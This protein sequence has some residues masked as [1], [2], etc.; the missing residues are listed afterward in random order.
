MQRWLKND[1]NK[2][3]YLLIVINIGR[4]PQK[5]QNDSNGVKN[6]EQKSCIFYGIHLSASYSTS[7]L[8]WFAIKEILNYR[9]KE[10]IK[11]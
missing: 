7:D 5:N 2:M 3:T 1:K 6:T 4:D 11:L 10:N 8:V 9:V